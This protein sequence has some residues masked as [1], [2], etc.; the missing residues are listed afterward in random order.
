MASW[1][2]IT[3]NFCF[4]FQFFRTACCVCHVPVQLDEMVQWHKSAASRWR[5]TSED[6]RGHS[7]PHVDQGAPVA[8]GRARA[9]G[10]GARA[11]TQAG[12]TCPG[13]PLVSELPQVTDPHLH[14]WATPAGVPVCP[15]PSHPCSHRALQVFGSSHPMLTLVCCQQWLTATASTHGLTAGKAEETQRGRET[16]QA[17]KKVIMRYCHRGRRCRV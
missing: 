1:F 8:C 5:D 12:P 10:K 3:N 7:Q 2:R 15:D 14:I 9:A 4:F 17:A 13:S 16:G 6:L 11:R